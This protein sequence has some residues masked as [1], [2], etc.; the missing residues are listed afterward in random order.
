MAEL[1]PGEANTASA[2]RTVSEHHRARDQKARGTHDGWRNMLDRDANAQIR[3]APEDIDQPEGNN[4][5]PSTW[6]RSD[7][8]ESS[9]GKNSGY[10]SEHKTIGASA[11]QIIGSFKRKNIGT[12]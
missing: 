11:D 8:H 1:A 7:A 5:L 3:R 6:G 9:S 2:Q 12:A 10:Q 4:D